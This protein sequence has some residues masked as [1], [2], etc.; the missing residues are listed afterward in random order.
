MGTDFSDLRKVHF[1]NDKSLETKHQRAS[2]LV[3]FMVSFIYLYL[4]E[5]EERM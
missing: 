1:K 4:T 2:K 5:I 3:E